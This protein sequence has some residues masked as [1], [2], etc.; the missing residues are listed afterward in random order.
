MTTRE[1]TIIEQGFT[2]AMADWAG[3]YADN[4]DWD[5]IRA[6]Y[7]AELDRL[8]PEGVDWGW[9][10]GGVLCTAEISVDAETVHERWAEIQS[11]QLIDFEGIA[12]RHDR[13]LA[14]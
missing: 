10:E 2:T 5:A 4:F 14:K 11:E 9:Y 3:E 1:I 7:N 12:T 8:A 6:D 13:T